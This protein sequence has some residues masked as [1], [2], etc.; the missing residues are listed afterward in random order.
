V[1]LDWDRDWARAERELERALELNPG[2]A[3]ARGLYGNFRVMMGSSQK[4]VAHLKR[5]VELDP[6][7]ASRHLLLSWGYYFGRQFDEALG[8][9]RKAKEL[10]PGGEHWFLALTL[11]ELGTYEEAIAEFQKAEEQAD[12]G[13]VGHL[14]NAYARAGRVSEARE[15]LRELKQRFAEEGVGA[16][17]IALIHGGLGE[18]EQAFEWLERAYEVRDRGLLYL[19]VDPPLDPLRSDR[20]FHELVRRMN[21]P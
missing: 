5:A 6:L 14:G 13:F 12:A 17:E 10:D 2:S 7:S 8:A 9:I 16:Y 1:V 3:H 19:K 4:G 11:R 21:F 20:R 18:R 15:V